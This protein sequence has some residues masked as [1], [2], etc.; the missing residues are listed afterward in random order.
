M[1]LKLKIKI[2]ILETGA[3]VSTSHIETL[4]RN[5]KAEVVQ[6]AI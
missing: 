1:K 5:P 3:I 4:L 6:L 2:G